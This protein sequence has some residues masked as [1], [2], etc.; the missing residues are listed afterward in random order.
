MFS[1]FPRKLQFSYVDP[2]GDGLGEDIAREQSNPE[3]LA[4]QDEVDGQ[5]LT[6]FWSQVGKDIH[7][8]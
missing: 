4:F 8:E 1:P 6:E 3:V 7:G 5:S 2:L